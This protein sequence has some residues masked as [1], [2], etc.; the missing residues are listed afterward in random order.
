MS[1]AKWTAR[2]VTHSGFLTLVIE[3]LR[4]SSALA[5]EHARYARRGERSR[6]ATLAPPARAA[7]TAGR[8]ARALDGPAVTGGLNRI[9]SARPKSQAVHSAALL[10]ELPA[11]LDSVAGVMSVDARYE[12]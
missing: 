10:P 6:G 7:R 12:A 4:R 8:P 1:T 5:D 11:I 9:V 2:E 3:A